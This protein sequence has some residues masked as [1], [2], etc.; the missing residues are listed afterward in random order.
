MDAAWQAY[1]EANKI[2]DPEAP[3]GEYKLNP[4]RKGYKEWFANPKASQ[5]SPPQTFP[6]TQR[7]WDALSPDQKAKF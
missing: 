2:F 1:L 7:E 6:G 4:A 3:M 5:S